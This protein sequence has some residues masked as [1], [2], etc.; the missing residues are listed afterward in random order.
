MLFNR[1]C[2]KCGVLIRAGSYCG[3]CAPTYVTP[4]REAKK[5]FLYGGDYKKR[6]KIVRE[7][8]THC[9]LC[10]KPFQGGDIVEADHL[11]PEQGHRS[12]L[13]GAHRS[14]NRQ[15]GNT[16]LTG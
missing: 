6:A 7:N 1:P 13:A 12:P 2:L 4:Q 14:C 11:Y 8:S 9:H 15:R 10:G 3:G 16:P 5:E